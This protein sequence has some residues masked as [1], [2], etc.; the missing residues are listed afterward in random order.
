MQSV[1][2]NDRVGNQSMKHVVSQASFDLDSVGAEEWKH[3]AHYPTELGKDELCVSVGTKEYRLALT[4][5]R[6]LSTPELSI[7]AYPETARLD[8]R[9][10]PFDNKL[11]EIGTALKDRKTVQSSHA[12]EAISDS[13]KLLDAAIPGS[14]Y[15]QSLS[16]GGRALHWKTNIDTPA[17]EVSISAIASRHVNTC[18]FTKKTSVHYSLKTS[19]RSDQFDL[20]SQRFDGKHLKD[21][22]TKADA[23]LKAQNR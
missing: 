16:D 3:P 18:R 21:L 22:Y 10:I 13:M 14:R 9:T 17:G 23:A 2:K 20:G 6:D 19:S 1:E 8:N 12:S 7:V 15:E 5:R 11:K 4:Q